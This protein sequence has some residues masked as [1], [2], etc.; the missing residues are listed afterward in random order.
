MNSKYDYDII[1][2]YLH[3]LTDHETT[4]RIREL[5]RTDDIARNIAAGIL[6]LEHDF[7]G[8]ENEIEAYIESLHQKNRKIID[9]Q[10]KPA[11]SFGWVKLAAAIL[12][13]AVVGSVVWLTML[14]PADKDLLAQ[15][16]SEP[17]PVS[18]TDR[19][20]SNE[21]DA[22]EGFES[23][24]KRDYKAAISWFKNISNDDPSIIFYNGLSN[25]YSGDYNTAISLLGSPALTGSRY[26]QQA[27]WYQTLA[28][29]KANTTNAARMNLELISSKPG[30]FK[31]AEARQLLE[32]LD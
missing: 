23:Y 5:I 1:S 14:K 11:S 13:I 16:L 25:L 30:N 20:T 2:D 18:V 29:L 4:K 26:R 8:N 19:S 6:Q 24:R 15:E 3:G 22:A 9:E 28:M 32:S 21:S 12:V 7:K 10:T 27:L 17:Y 31:S